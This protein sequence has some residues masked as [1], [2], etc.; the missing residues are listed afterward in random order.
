MGP[1]LYR[2]CEIARELTSEKNE[3]GQG[4]CTALCGTKKGE[5]CAPPTGGITPLPPSGKN[6]IGR[7][8]RELAGM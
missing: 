6:C 8:C 3:S 2:C 4:N 7:P 1:E 5:F